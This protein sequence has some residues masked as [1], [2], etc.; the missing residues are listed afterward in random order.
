MAGHLAGE[1]Q[2]PQSERVLG[3]IGCRASPS[4]GEGDEGEALSIN[5]RPTVNYS[6]LKT[7]VSAT[8]TPR[9]DL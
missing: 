6:G 4:D 5:N 2:S 3:E 9:S 7:G 8:P 1:K